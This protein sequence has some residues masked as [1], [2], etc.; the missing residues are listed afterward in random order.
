MDRL[1]SSY[2]VQVKSA[3]TGA[4]GNTKHKMVILL[5]NGG[6]GKSK[7]AGSIFRHVWNGICL[8]YGEIVDNGYMICVCGCTVLPPSNHINP[9]IQFTQHNGRLLM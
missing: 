2:S 6:L 8:N 3:S 1:V 4:I 7:H 9:Q 5:A